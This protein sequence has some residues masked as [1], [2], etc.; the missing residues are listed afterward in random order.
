[1]RILT[2]KEAEDF[3]EKEGFNILERKIAK[4]EKDLADIKKRIKFP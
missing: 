2:E 3:L 1:M 4:E